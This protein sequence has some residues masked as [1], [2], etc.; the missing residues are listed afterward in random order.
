M[1]QSGV[2]G[3]L[4]YCSDYHC[5]HHIEMN[6]D[7]WP[8]SVRLSDLEP[9]FVCQDCGK[10]GAEV[11]Q[12]F[13]AAMGNRGASRYSGARRQ[14]EREINHWQLIRVRQILD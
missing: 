6:A 10:N 4:I 14:A 2:R 7:R 3:L 5:A 12:D 11:R 8:D 1:R 9:R 13:P